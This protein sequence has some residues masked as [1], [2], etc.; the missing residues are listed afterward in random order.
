MITKI[1]TGKS[2]IAILRIAKRARTAIVVEQPQGL[3]YTD[4]TIEDVFEK[5]LTLDM[6]TVNAILAVYSA[7]S[8]KNK[9]IFMS[10][11]WVSIGEKA[12][13]LIG[14]YQNKIRL[15]E[16][17]EVSKEDKKSVTAS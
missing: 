10:W 16:F 14:K 5:P 17:N 2:K 4:V 3:R 8:K 9:A 15:K 1:R 12:W 7:L 13:E 6:T 11:S